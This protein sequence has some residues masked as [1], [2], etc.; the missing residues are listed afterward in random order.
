M[1]SASLQIYEVRIIVTFNSK[2]MKRRFRGVVSLVLEHIRRVSQN[3][4]KG[5]KEGGK[6]KER[7][8]GSK[9]M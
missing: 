7:E 9:E 2:K 8:G 5:K 4:K 1:C 3:F 6:K